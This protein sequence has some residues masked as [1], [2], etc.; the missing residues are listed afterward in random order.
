MTKNS[1]NITPTA[2]GDWY[3]ETLHNNVRVHYRM[4]SILYQ[5]KTEFQDMI[6]FEN[7]TFGRM[8]AL[9]GVIQTTQ[10]DEP[11]Y[12]EMLTH[13]PIIAHGAVKNVL[14]IGGGD[15]GIARECLK[16]KNTTVTMVELDSSVTDF[17]KQHLPTLSDGAFNNDRL[18]LIFTDGCHYVANTTERFDVIIVDSTD[19]IGVGEV[20]FTEQFY[21]NCKRCLTQGGVLVSQQGVPSLQADEIVNTTRRQRP[22]FAHVGFYK[23]MVGTYFGGFMTLGWATDNTTLHTLDVATITQRVQGADLGALKYYTPAEHVA[24]FSLPQFVLDVLATA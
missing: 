8:L 24:S 14:I 4:E 13:V 17:S 10:A 23:T 15:G 21:T 5:D 9:D 2:D 3:A 16:H 18:N 6:L 19:P 20:L 7:P 12:H 1:P 11:A 22:H